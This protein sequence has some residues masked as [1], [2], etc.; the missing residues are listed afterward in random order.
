MQSAIWIFVVLIFFL[1]T[2]I[3][4]KH[5]PKKYEG[6]RLRA[7]LGAIY[8]IWAILICI[9][10]SAFGFDFFNGVALFFGVA[11]FACIVFSQI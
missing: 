7:T 1:G 2:L 6:D 5:L 4:Q 9:V 11:A 10:L 8:S 3:L